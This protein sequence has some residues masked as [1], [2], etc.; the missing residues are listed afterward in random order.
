MTEQETFPFPRDLKY[1]NNN[2]FSC[3]EGKEMKILEIESD[4]A[5]EGSQY[6]KYLKKCNSVLNESPNASNHHKISFCETFAKWE[7]K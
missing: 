5:F 2:F 6:S 1:E 3:P 4:T 7:L